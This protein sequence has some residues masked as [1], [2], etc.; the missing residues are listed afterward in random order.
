MVPYS[1]HTFHRA[2]SHLSVAP[3]P[4]RKIQGVFIGHPRHTQALSGPS[5][6]RDADPVPMA[7]P[8]DARRASAILS[9]A[10]CLAESVDP[11]KAALY[12]KAHSTSDQIEKPA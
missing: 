10:I 11:D 8:P 7:T 9:P 6:T 1:L 2:P 3:A 12:H 5:L 4:S